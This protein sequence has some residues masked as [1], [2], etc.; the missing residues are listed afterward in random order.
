MANPSNIQHLFSN[1]EILPSIQLNLRDL[2]LD[3][4][5]VLFQQ[6]DII[7]N[8][9]CFCFKPDVVT[10][11]REAK[12][13]RQMLQKMTK[14]GESG[15]LNEIVEKLLNKLAIVGAEP[16]FQA[17]IL[18]IVSNYWINVNNNQIEEKDMVRTWIEK[19]SNIYKTVLHPKSCIISRIKYLLEGK[20]Y[21]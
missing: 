19:A 6:H 10:A 14:H 18:E 8:F 11:L 7:C 21:E 20:N 1:H 5:L 15:D 12:E 9:G 4:K 3:R 2:D 13:G 17:Y 16:I